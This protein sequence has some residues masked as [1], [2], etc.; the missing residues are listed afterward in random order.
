[1]RPNWDETGLELANTIA[2]RAACRR[3]QVGAVVVS[4]DRLNVFLGYN[5]VP[6][7]EIHCS[8]G[9]CP[10]GMLSAEECPPGFSYE[11]CKAIH[12]E[13]NAL[14]RAGIYAK[15]GTLYVTRTPC[16]D[17]DD[18]AWEYGIERIVW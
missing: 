7:G 15:G 2:K 9:G 5:G 8:D 18:L 13:R 14:T 10:R 11:N 3:S 16:E 4:Q 1:M 6:S 12:A 17:C